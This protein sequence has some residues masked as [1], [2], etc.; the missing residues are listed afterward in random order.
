MAEFWNPA[1]A[2]QVTYGPSGT[3]DSGNV[4][5][6]VTQPLGDPSYYAINAQLQGGGTVSCSIEVNGVA[7]STGSASGG[8]NIAT[9]EIGQDPVTGACQNDNDG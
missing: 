1:R 8:Y 3:D 9:C 4:P 7:I 2:A 5:M 6:S